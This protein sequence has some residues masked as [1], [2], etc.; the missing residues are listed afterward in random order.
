MQTPPSPSTHLHPGLP[1]VSAHFGAR[2]TVAGS[3]PLSPGKPARLRSGPR[4]ITRVGNRDPRSAVYAAQ[5][6]TMELQRWEG[7][8]FPSSDGQQQSMAQ[9]SLQHQQVEKYLSSHV[10]T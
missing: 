7:G 1:C 9:G 10:L 6:Q 8:L 3:A 4:L 5:L 2:P